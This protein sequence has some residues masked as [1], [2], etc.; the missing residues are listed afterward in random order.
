MAAELALEQAQCSRVDEYRRRKDTAVLA[1]AFADIADSTAL[2]EQLGE[3]RYDA[4]RRQHNETVR[5]VVEEDEAG[6][7]V[8]F[9]GDGALAVF[10]EPSTA[11]E[12]CLDLVSLERGPFRLRIGVDVGQVARR[13][14]D[15]TVLEV[16]GR[17]VNRAA[18]IESLA[19]PGHVL[20]SYAVYDFSVGWLRSNGVEWRALGVATPKGFSEPVSIHEPFRVGGGARSRRGSRIASRSGQVADGSNTAAPRGGARGFDIC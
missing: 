19:E 13:S 20:A 15:G 9:Y 11:V 1:I 8:Q 5:G 4:L 10:S 16:F 7:L 18:R 6:S 12:R 17:H 3:N 2:L 14:R